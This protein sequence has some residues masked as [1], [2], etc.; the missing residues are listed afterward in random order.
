MADFGE[1]K[2]VKLMTQKHKGTL[3]GTELYMAP[4]LFNSLYYDEVVE[5]NPYKSDVF[6]V[7]YCVL[8]AATLSFNI[9]YELRK[10]TSKKMIYEVINKYL[11]GSYSAKFICLMCRMV[12]YNEKYRFDFIQLKGF[13]EKTF[14]NE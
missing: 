12:E 6:S 1:A 2:E 11:S 10:V 8:F 5:H 3:R 14:T 4:A 7:G 9:L 13:L